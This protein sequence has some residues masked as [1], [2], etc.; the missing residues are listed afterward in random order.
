MGR[1]PGGEITVEIV[2]DMGS[3]RELRREWDDLLARS[4]NPDVLHSYAWYSSWC[5]WFLPPGGMLIAT[6]RDDG[7]LAA[8]LPLMK[9]FYGGNWLRLKA[10][11]SMTNCHSDVFDVLAREAS[12][13]GLRLMIEAVF[14]STGLKVIVLD[15]I[16]ESAALLRLLP[17]ACEGFPHVVRRVDEEWMIDLAEGFDGVFRRIKPKFRKNVIASER[18]MRENRCQIL[19]PEGRDELLCNLDRG[20][21]VEAKGWKGRLGTAVIQ[22]AAAK[23]FFRE[24]TGK[25]AEAGWA[26]MLLAGDNGDAMSF[27]LCLGGFGRIHALKIGMDERF[28]ALGP[29]MV[30]TKKML[31]LVSEE[32]QFSTWTFGPG[33][34]RWKR[35]WSGRCEKRC[36]IFIFENDAIGKTL[37]AATKYYDKN[38]P[39][40]GNGARG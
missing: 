13:R 16:L 5:N 23:G 20:L 35:D 10:I 37:Y 9:S 19:R 33:G 15:K 27:L 12:P 39:Y 28:R 22:D 2:R 1:G 40:P 6:V 7:A 8:L 26:R 21:A 24:M 25:F 17:E 36:R 4:D 29:G 3:L 31:E 11:K 32:K 34:E 14:R 38:H 30:V 18:K